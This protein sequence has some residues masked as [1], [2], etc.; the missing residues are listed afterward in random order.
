MEPR[1]L[2][3]GIIKVKIICLFRCYSNC[4]EMFK[5]EKHFKFIEFIYLLLWI[6]TIQIFLSWSISLWLCPKKG[7][8]VNLRIK[9][10]FLLNFFYR[11]F[12]ENFYNLLFSVRRTSIRLI[13][14]NVH[15]HKILQW[16]NKYWVKAYII[17]IVDS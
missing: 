6:Q 4:T 10:T 5:Q 14:S 16:H 3:Y 15:S 13:Y 1:K 11:D 17:S 9:R 7:I 8:Q 2:F 12:K